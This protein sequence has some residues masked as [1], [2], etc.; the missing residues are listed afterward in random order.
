MTPSVYVIQKSTGMLYCVTVQ[1]YEKYKDKY[2][3]HEPVEKIDEVVEEVKIEKSVPK[4]TRKIK[5]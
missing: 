2:D 4:R 1:H 3:K 5:E